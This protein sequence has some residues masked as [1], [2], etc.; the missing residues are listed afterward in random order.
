MTQSDPRIL[1]VFAL[2]SRAARERQLVTYSELA[3]GVGCHPQAE[4]GRILYRI[5]GVCKDNGYPPITALAVSKG[6]LAP[7]E[8]LWKVF[9]EVQAT[10]RNSRWTEM[11]REVYL[12][13]WKNVPRKS[14]L[15]ASENNA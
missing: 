5:A 15:G 6:S 4:L 13:D 9:S 3:G 1:A 14:F 12:F 10:G 7:S 8:G 11:I 2:L